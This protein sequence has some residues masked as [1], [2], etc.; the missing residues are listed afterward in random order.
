MNASK[1]MLEKRSSILS[2]IKESNLEKW[3]SLA[4]GSDASHFSVDL[5]NSLDK[6]IQGL[7]IA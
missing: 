7:E 1:N 4:L 5:S 3:K 2:S 6:Q